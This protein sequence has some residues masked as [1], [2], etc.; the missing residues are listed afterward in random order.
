MED[1]RIIKTNL[2]FLPHIGC[3]AASPIPIKITGN[4]EKFIGMRLLNNS[5]IQLLS[6]MMIGVI[7]NICRDNRKR[8]V[9]I[10]LYL[11]TCVVSMDIY[12]FIGSGILRYSY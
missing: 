7:S 1:F 9:P 12:P 4:L 6:G 8:G 11:T 2:Y 10:I 5:Y 3:F